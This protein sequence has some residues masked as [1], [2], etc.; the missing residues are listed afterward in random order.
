[1]R[2]KSSTC[3]YARMYVSVYDL[4]GP[5]TSKEKEF[6]AGKSKTCRAS[7]R[8]SHWEVSDRISS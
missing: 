4:G 5:E 3:R 7:E 2:G 6:A 1:M 8:Q